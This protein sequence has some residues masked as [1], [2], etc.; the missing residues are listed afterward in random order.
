MIHDWM[1]ETGLIIM[2]IFNILCLVGLIFLFLYNGI[3]LDWK[4]DY[5]RDKDILMRPQTLKERIFRLFL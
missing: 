4:N 3:Y 2:L 5:Y 1:R